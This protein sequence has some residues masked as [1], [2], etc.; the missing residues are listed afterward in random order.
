MPCHIKISDDV[1]GMSKE[2]C[3]LLMELIN[4]INVLGLATGSSQTRLYHYLI[5]AY[6]SGSIDFS[7]IKTFNLDEYYK[8]NPNFS[9]SYRYYMDTHFFNHINL[10]KE[11]INFLNGLTNDPKNECLRYE[12][13]YI[14]WRH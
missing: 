5:K 7:S 3:K 11:N 8:I 4:S 14:S 13:D 6:R 10:P 9:L 12:K 1:L 2:V